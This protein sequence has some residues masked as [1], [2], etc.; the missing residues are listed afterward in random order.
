MVD[1][2][3]L[4]VSAEITFHLADLA[5]PGGPLPRSRGPLPLRWVSA[6]E[7]ESI[8]A[9]LGRDDAVW[10]SF[11][12]VEP[13]SLQMSI[14]GV[15]V[16]PGRRLVLPDQRWLDGIHGQD[17]HAAQVC[18]PDPGTRRRIHAVA[19]RLRGDAFLAWWRESGA[20]R[21]ANRFGEPEMVAG[22]G[23]PET[24]PRVP[25]KIE[26]DPHGADRWEA[27]PF[28]EIEVHL[29]DP[30]AWADLGFGESG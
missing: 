24:G 23:A 17:G 25:Q 5:A 27:E 28:D 1:T 3:H 4:G 12:A 10:L 16:A 13:V 6:P 2:L 7:G 19:R 11:R 26:D 14:D 9:P 30:R 22:G 15:D 29:I 18:G 8:V 20:R 21:R